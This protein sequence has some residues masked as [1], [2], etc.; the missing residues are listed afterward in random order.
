MWLECRFELVLNFQPQGH[1][2]FFPIFHELPVQ[3]QLLYPTTGRYSYPIYLRKR[4]A[5]PEELGEPLLIELSVLG[6]TTVA[7]QDHGLFRILRV[8][9][10][11]SV[12]VLTV[13]N[14]LPLAAKMK[15]CV[16]ITSMDGRRI[17]KNLL[18][19][20]PCPAHSG[21]FN[22]IK[23]KRCSLI[24]LGGWLY[25]THGEY[26]P[27]HAPPAFTLPTLTPANQLIPP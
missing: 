6:S 12:G 26:F 11:D 10:L 5:N 2:G 16:G 13:W 22:N 25:S 27:P 3:H 17:P 20:E 1:A 19:F 7:D 23:V 4:S 24:R 14:N 18:L 8:V 9:D 21:C 15:Y